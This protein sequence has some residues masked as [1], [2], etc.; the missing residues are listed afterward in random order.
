[1]TLAAFAPLRFPVFRLLWGASL[2]ASTCMWMSDIASAWLMTSL[3]SSPLMVAMV[4]TAA[5]LPVF[6]LG[7]PS[8]ALADILDRRRW[9]MFTQLW[10]AAIAMLLAAGM[11]LGVLGP[12]GLL[13]LTFANGVGLAM[14]WPVFSAIVPELVPRSTLGAALGL[15]ALAINGSRIAGALLAGLIIA[16]AGVE[17]VFI[18]NALV[19]LLAAGMIWRW[20]RPPPAPAA[21]PG[22]RFFGAMRVGWQYVRQSPRMHGVLLRIALFFLQSAGLMALLPLTA[23]R[24]QAGGAGVFTLLLVTM[25]GGAILGAV[26]LPRAAARWSR[27]VLVRVGTLAQA[28]ATLVVA[29]TSE[30]WIACG[31]MFMAGMAW[32]AV[33]NTLTVAAQAALPDWVRA[34]GMAIFQMCFMGGNAAGAALWGMVASMAGLQQAMLGSA[35]SGLLITLFAWKVS[36]AGASPEALAPTPHW[37]APPA[38]T[39]P[40]QSE[41]GPVLVT[42]EYLID[43]EH[44]GQFQAVMALARRAR[45]R[46]GALSWELLR[47]IND[48]GRWVE[49]FVDESWV[50]HLR[51]FERV[52]MGDVAL[53]DRVLAL[54]GG[55][56]PPR[57]SR[58]L[59]SPVQA[60]AGVV[61][62]IPRV[63][64][65]DS[66]QGEDR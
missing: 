66:S 47:D 21:L 20:R 48:A 50:E 65:R 44:V 33:G 37:S 31:G 40:L 18:V 62:E 56:Q 52:T 28:G 2:L 1:M 15:N 30:P 4:Q 39:L 3:S 19:S 49:Y 35:V 51:R 64:R 29:L 32:I 5:M 23:H 54:H 34:R 55:S 41:D 17:F 9:F 25:G 6:L 22:E 38:A 24:L 58:Y 27:D 60:G 61:S 53:R 36:V 42:I 57:V 14:R 11:L 45:L 16:S 46:Q 13:I 43:P 26:W 7:L 12:V 59:V 8:G 10:V 63:T